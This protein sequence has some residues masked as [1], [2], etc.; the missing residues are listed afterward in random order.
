M[1]DHILDLTTNPLQAIGVL[2]F[3]AYMASF[4]LLQARVIDGNGPAYC[5]LN[6]I[7][8]S[9]VLISLADAFNLASLLTQLSWIVIGLA[10]LASR[11]WVGRSR[12]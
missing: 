1:A 8:A 6:V 2:G 7:A 9:L 3:V 10:G 11:F 5:L 4:A 12:R